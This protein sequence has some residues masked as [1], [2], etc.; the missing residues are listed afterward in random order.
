MSAQSFPASDHDPDLGPCCAGRRGAAEGAQVRAVLLLDRKSPEPGKGWGCVV[1][2]L[3]PDGASAVLCD[4]CAAAGRDPVEA[5]L[6][7]PHEGRRLPLD[8]LGAPHEH[9]PSRH[10]E[11]E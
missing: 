5:C 11:M 6:G 7:Y 1:C 8:Q 3:P 4:D 9:D 10:P 2:G